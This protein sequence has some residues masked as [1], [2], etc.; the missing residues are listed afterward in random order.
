MPLEMLATT[1]SSTLAVNKLCCEL[2]SDVPISSPL[3][4]IQLI[5]QQIIGMR[6]YFAIPNC[7]TFALVQTNP[8]S[9]ANQSFLI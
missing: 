2:N 9:V 4:I 1:L 3:V 8:R 5:S 6:N 7:A